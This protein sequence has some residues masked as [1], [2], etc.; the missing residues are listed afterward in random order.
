MDGN[1]DLYKKINKFAFG[2]YASIIL[3][4]AGLSM[5]FQYI[6][7]ALWATSSIHPTKPTLFFVSGKRNQFLGIFLP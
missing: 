5:G 2:I 7:I 4:L 6:A 1:V 3:T